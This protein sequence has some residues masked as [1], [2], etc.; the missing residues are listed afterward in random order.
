M[1]VARLTRFSLRGL[2]L[3]VLVASLAAWRWGVASRQGALISGL[4]DA[5]FSICRSS[6]EPCSIVRWRSQSTQFD[7]QLSGCD[8]GSSLAQVLSAGNVAVV[9]F[10][11]E[12]VDLGALRFLPRLRSVTEFEVFGPMRSED[13]V[14]EAIATTSGVR[15]L[16][17]SYSSLSVVA[18]KRLCQIRSLRQLSLYQTSVSKECLGDVAAM[19]DLEE[20]ALVCVPCD[21][22]T[23]SRF[24]N[25]QR[26]RALDLGRSEIT[27]AGISAIA[28]LKELDFL[29][30]RLTRISDASIDRLLAFNLLKR[31][32]VR[33]TYITPNGIARLRSGLV[34]CEVWEDSTTQYRFPSMRRTP[35]DRHDSD[36]GGW[37]LPV[38]R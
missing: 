38:V 13:Q 34:H 32:D 37:A 17:V 7:C 1:N 33:G 29:S 3:F 5:G 36:Y 18:F 2:M 11:P 20:L 8:R 9:S 35:E 24:N 31:L 21:D 26:L 6:A 12:T 23:A 28:P 15:R 22:A 14:V 16:S 30:V 19:A 4:E 10:S 25:L 27:D